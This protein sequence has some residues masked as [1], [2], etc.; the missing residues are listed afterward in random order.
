MP[1]F[2]RKDQIK[3]KAVFKQKLK[4]RKAR[5]FGTS[6]GFSLARIERFEISFAGFTVY[7]KSSQTQCLSGFIAFVILLHFTKKHS[8]S[9]E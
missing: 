5:I 4:P 9:S 1:A 7:Y 2:Y 3:T 6:Q 8:I